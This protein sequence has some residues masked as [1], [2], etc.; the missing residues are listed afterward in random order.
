MLRDRIQKQTYPK[1]RNTAT[2]LN[3]LEELVLIN[4]KEVGLVPID[5]DNKGYQDI[6]LP[7]GRIIPLEVPEEAVSATMMVEQGVVNVITDP[8]P[9]ETVSII[10]RSNKKKRTPPI[11]VLELPITNSSAVLRFKENGSNPNINSGFG[12]G[13]QDIFELVGSENLKKFRVIGVQ[14]NGTPILRI[15]FYKTAQFE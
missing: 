5:Q 12:L 14:K 2:I 11:P 9:D 15:Q 4:A 7:F 13:N 10:A 6:P 1:R 3:Y 8:D